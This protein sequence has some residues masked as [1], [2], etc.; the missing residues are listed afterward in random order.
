MG[1]N[2]PHAHMYTLGIMIRCASHIFALY[3]ATADDTRHGTALSVWVK[4]FNPTLRCKPEILP[5]THT[6][7]HFST[8]KFQPFGTISFLD[9]RHIGGLLQAESVCV[10][11]PF[12]VTCPF[13]P[14]FASSFSHH[15][16]HHRHRR[17]LRNVQLDAC[18]YR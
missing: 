8:L 13:C 12:A 14:R 7:L 16:Q 10:G 4:I 11:K 15:H 9:S 1:K 6:Y 17:R 18:R 3:F 5:H 2:T